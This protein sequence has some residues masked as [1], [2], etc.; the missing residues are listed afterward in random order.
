MNSESLTLVATYRRTIQASLERIW[1]NVRDWEHLPWLH[2]Y[3]FS[4]IRLLDQTPGSWKA[5]IIMPPANAPREAVIELQLDPAHLRYWSRTLAGLGAGGEILTCLKPLDE[6][7]TNII[8]E[9]RVPGINAKQAEALGAAYLRL[10]ARLWDEDE[11]MMRR[12]Q[13]LIDTQRIG[14]EPRVLRKVKSYE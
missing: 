4:S 12:R 5:Q 14:V 9:F 1:E 13:E 7:T 6:Q 3:S 11:R 10:Y 2:R 8:V